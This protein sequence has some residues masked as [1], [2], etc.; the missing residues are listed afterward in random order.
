M[1]HSEDRSISPILPIFSRC[2]AH[3]NLKLLRKIAGSIEP[4]QSA[5]LAD[6]KA[7]A[8][9][10]VC[11]RG[12]PAVEKILHGRRFTDMYSGGFYPFPSLEE[13][14][15]YWSRYI[16]INRYKD[17]DNGTY[18][19]LFKLVKDKDYFV[20]T[21]N[22]DHQFQKAGFDKK[23]LFYT[24]GDYGL[25]QCGGPCH[26]AVYD[27]ETVI[28]EMNRRQADMKIPSDLIPYCPR[29]GRPMTMNLRADDSFVQDDGWY[30]AEERYTDFIRG[31]RGLRV[32]FLE[33]GV[34]FNTPGIIKYPFWQMAYD[35]PHA[36]YVCINYG[37]SFVPEEIKGKSVCLQDDIKE[38]LQALSDK[39]RLAA[40]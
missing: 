29:C 21:T 36:R 20:L 14:W 23:R 7:C 26:H 15:A 3:S 25:L 31:H 35:N 13:H 4:A 1:P 39:N 6:R 12:D 22:V 11:C 24:Q 27:N 37:E 33:L 8:G 9:K 34:G 17:E 28:L 19:A 32:L 2:Y 10:L 18:K 40:I 30:R 16:L 5:D 38:V